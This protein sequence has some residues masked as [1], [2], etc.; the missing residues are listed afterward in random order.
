MLNSW[1]KTEYIQDSQGCGLCVWITPSECRHLSAPCYAR[2]SEVLSLLTTWLFWPT[3]PL[4]FLPTLLIPGSHC[5]SCVSMISPLFYFTVNICVIMCDRETGWCICV[6][7][8]SKPSGT[9]LLFILWQCLS[10]R[11]EI[12]QW[13]WPVRKHKGSISIYVPSDRTT[14]IFHHAQ[15]PPVGSRNPAQVLILT[16]EVLLQLKSAHSLYYNFILHTY[17]RQTFQ[18]LTCCVRIFQLA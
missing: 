16:W 13:S 1:I 5:L 12:C 18:R 10:Q 7:T 3:W 4:Y 15:L 9:V 17:R 14:A 6:E 11:P 2:V 8:R